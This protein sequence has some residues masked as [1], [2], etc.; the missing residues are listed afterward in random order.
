MVSFKLDEKQKKKN[1]IYSRDHYVE[2]ASSTI[3]SECFLGVSNFHTCFKGLVNFLSP[4]IQK[5]NYCLS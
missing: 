2:G 5:I 1:R 3:V 4:E